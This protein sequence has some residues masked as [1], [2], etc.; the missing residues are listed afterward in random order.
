[1]HERSLVHALLCQVE[2]LMR[3]QQADRVLNVHVS[4][5]EF[6]GVEPDLFRSAFEDVVIDSP[7]RGAQLNLRQVPLQARCDRCARKFLVARFCFECPACQ[8]K[9]VT[10]LRGEDLMLESVTLEQAVS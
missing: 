9:Q 3:Q 2:T 10:I 7:L 4:V 6:S 1:M 5:G 8:S